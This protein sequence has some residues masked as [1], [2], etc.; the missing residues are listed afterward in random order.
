MHAGIYPSKSQEMY[1][2]SIFLRFGITGQQYEHKQKV[3]NIIVPL[4]HKIPTKTGVY[5][6]AT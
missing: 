4:L 2:Y 6:A 3:I 5:F 1:D